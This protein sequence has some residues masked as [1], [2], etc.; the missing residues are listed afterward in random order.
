M[1]DPWDDGRTQAGFVVTSAGL[2]VPVAAPTSI[3]GWPSTSDTAAAAALSAPGAD[4]R[5]R[6]VGPRG[7]HRADPRIREQVCE[8]L[9]LDPYLDASG[10]V[11]QVSKGRIALTGTVPSERMRDSAVAAASSI[12]AGAVDDRLHV[13][14]GAPGRPSRLRA[15]AAGGAMPPAKSKSVGSRKR[16][17]SGKRAGARTSGGAR[18]RGGKR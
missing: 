10:V 17:G 2:R 11:V 18:G 12:A 7:Y 16:A 3:A 14:A 4:A 13:A 8:R 6:G 1:T 5:F 15:G 9:L